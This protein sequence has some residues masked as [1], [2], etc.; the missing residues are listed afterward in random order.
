MTQARDDYKALQDPKANVNAVDDTVVARYR[1]VYSNPMGAELLASQLNE[2][3]LFATIETPEQ[4]VRHN[5]AIQLLARVGVLRP[6]TNGVLSK[7]HM[8]KIVTALFQ[9]LE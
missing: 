1:A 4:M 2:L 5:Y 3:G 9:C 6:D 7:N 8:N